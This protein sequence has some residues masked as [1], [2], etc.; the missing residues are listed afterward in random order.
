MDGYCTA[1]N[2]NAVFSHLLKF[3]HGVMPE[4]CSQNYFNFL[5]VM[6]NILIE[7]YRIYN[8]KVDEGRERRV[9]EV[10]LEK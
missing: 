1:Q 9:A 4:N 6:L 8:R 5:N 2:V 3:T 10:P 7:N